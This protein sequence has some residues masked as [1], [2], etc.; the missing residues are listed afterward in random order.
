MGDSH[1]SCA[2]TGAPVYDECVVIV[3]GPGGYGD[4][5]APPRLSAGGCHFCASPHDDGPIYLPLTLP[6]RARVGSTW[7]KIDE[8]LDAEHDLYLRERWGAGAVEIVNSAIESGALVGSEIRSH[9]AERDHVESTRW[10][11][12]D[13]TDAGIDAYVASERARWESDL[14]RGRLT[15]DQIRWGIEDHARNARA[16]RLQTRAMKVA[17]KRGVYGASWCDAAHVRADVWDELTIERGFG[18]PYYCVS[19][20]SVALYQRHRTP[21]LDALALQ[22]DAFYSA[23]ASLGRL[24]PSVIHN[25]DRDLARTRA[26]VL[27]T[28]ARLAAASTE[29][30]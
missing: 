14:A 6:I 13:T 16:S 29:E 24:M 23:V 17:S 9:I 21:H 8:C 10:D 27:A 2:L 19:P 11:E 4:H 12:Y 26:R 22:L 28:A 1:V 20:Y 30:S 25:E 7:G 3:L 5:S 15:P 18:L